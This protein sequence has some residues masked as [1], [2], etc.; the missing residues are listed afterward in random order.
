M[1]EESLKN[2]KEIFNK[3]QKLEKLNKVIV[4]E[5][6]DKI[7]I[8]KEIKETKSRDIQIKWNFE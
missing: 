2:H 6:I 4:D 5:F 1:K 7:Y 8:G 3:Y